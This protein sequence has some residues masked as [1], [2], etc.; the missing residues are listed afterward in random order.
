[1][2]AIPFFSATKINT[3]EEYKRFYHVKSYI[4]S[5]SKD[6]PTTLELM[7]KTGYRDLNKFRRHREAFDKLGRNIPL[8][9]L[10][11]IKVQIETLKFCAELDMEQFKRACEIKPLYPKYG[12]V[13]YS[14]AFY[15][16]ID[17]LAGMDEENAIGLIKRFSTEK[18]I[19]CFINYPD[20]KTVFIE[21]DSKVH[22]VYFPPQMHFTKHWLIIGKDGKRIGKAYIK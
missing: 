21:P 15:S 13:R 20:F 22:T 11:A 10:K 1:L 7:N 5:K 16:N 6:F 18:H 3:I 4:Q 17:I 12:A 8:L 9:Y 19:R 2:K 14:A